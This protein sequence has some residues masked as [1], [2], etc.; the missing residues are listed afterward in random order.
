MNSRAKHA[1]SDFLGLF[2]FKIL[3]S[4]DREER[5]VLLSLHL[6]K[7]RKRS[8]I[9]L[10]INGGLKNAGFF[11]QIRIIAYSSLEASLQ[12]FTVLFIQYS[13]SI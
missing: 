8:A 3:T 1:K 11:T 4:G 2:S 13:L 6:V 12:S 10:L 9:A 7:G 5:C